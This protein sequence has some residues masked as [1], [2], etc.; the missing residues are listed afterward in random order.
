MQCKLFVWLEF[1]IF[2]WFLYILTIYLFDQNFVIF[3]WFLY[4]L[5]VKTV[6]VDYDWVAKASNPHFCSV[7]LAAAAGKCNEWVIGKN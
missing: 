4:I 5:A 6:S 3:C 7:E 2:C 1:V